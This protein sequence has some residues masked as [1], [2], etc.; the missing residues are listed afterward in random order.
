MGGK[1]GRGSK[2]WQCYKLEGGKLVRLSPFCPRCGPGYFMA[3]HGD[4][5]TCGACHYTV[6]KSEDEKSR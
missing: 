3:D 5:Y 4:R 2:V 6:F 1:K